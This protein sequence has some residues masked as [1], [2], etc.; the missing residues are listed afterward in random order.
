MQEQYKNANDKI[1][2]PQELLE[3]TRKQIRAE[4]KQAQDGMYC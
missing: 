4:K 3:R 2:A 1:H